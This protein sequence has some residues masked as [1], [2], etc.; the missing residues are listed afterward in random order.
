M[1]NEKERKQP[2]SLKGSDSDPLIY[3]YLKPSGSCLICN[4]GINR[5]SLIRHLT[6][7]MEKKG[8]QRADPPSF[9]LHFS[10]A[11]ESRYYRVVLIRPEATF[12]DLDHLLKSMLGEEGDRSSRFQF[13]GQYYFSH[14][15]DGY[16]GMNTP[17]KSSPIRN[18][19]FLYLLYGPGWFPTIITGKFMGELLYAPKGG[20]MV[21]V[22]AVNEIPEEYHIWPQRPKEVIKL[23]E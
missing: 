20:K 12:Y 22:V 3:P 5:R 15:N 13:E 14:M 16:P 1:S 18:E 9:L 4:E 8:R 6:P 11:Q 17:I 23:Q 2:D 21:E 7:C 10:L 19:N